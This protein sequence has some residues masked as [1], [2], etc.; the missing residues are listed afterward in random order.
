MAYR[1]RNRLGLT[2][3]L[4]PSIPRDHGL[5]LN[6]TAP[7]CSYAW[8]GYL[9]PSGARTWIATHTWSRDMPNGLVVGSHFGQPGLGNGL[10]ARNENDAYK[11]LASWRSK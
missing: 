8:R 7:P 5:R 6:V 4:H 10:G 3:T 2:Q 11:P 9:V 1:C